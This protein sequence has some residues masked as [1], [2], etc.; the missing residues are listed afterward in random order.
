MGKIDDLRPSLLGGFAVSILDLCG[1]ILAE[2]RGRGRVGQSGGKSATVLLNAAGAQPEKAKGLERSLPREKL[3]L[4]HLIAATRL[5]ECDYAAGHRCHD[6]CGEP[7]TSGS[8]GMGAR[9]WTG[10]GPLPANLYSVPGTTSLKDPN[11]R[12]PSG[13]SPLTQPR[14]SAGSRTARD[15]V[16]ADQRGYCGL[17]TCDRRP[18]RQT[19]HVEAGVRA[20]R[21]YSHAS[22]LWVSNLPRQAVARRADIRSFRLL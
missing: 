8:S 17:K 18:S 6:L 22:R 7:P 5:L 13:D 20:G 2:C 15:A 12:P 11:I 1:D 3:L 9:S 4:R 10:F 16:R 21:G 14:K 19:K